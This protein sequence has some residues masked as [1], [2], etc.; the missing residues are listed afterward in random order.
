MS[1]M[2]FITVMLSRNS[3]L[4]R[5]FGYASLELGFALTTASVFYLASVSKQFT[6]AS[7]VLAAEQGYLRTLSSSERW[8]LRAMEILRQLT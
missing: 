7:I 6:A 5:S 3:D 2:E 4:Q 1:D 8:P